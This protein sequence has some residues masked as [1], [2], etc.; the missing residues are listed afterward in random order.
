[1]GQAV[2]ERGRS[3]GGLLREWRERRRLSQLALAH[4]AEISPRHLSFVETGRARPSREMVL[5]LAEHLNVPL[6][7]RNHLLLAAGYAP[8][9]P[10][11]ALDSP[12]LRRVRAA[13]RLVLRAHE[14]WP[15]VAVDRLWRLVDANAA[16]PVLTAGAAPHLLRPPVNALR[17]TLH[18]EG[19]APRVVNLGQWRTH[20]L[21]RLRRQAALTA[22]ADLAALHDELSG[23]P[24]G[25]PGPAPAE[26]APGDV[27]VPLRLRHGGGELHLLS[28]VSTFGTPLDVTVAE[29]SI[30]TFLPADEATAEA[31]RGA[32]G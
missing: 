24:G 23:Y 32:V 20:V 18:P 17:L 14:P 10:Q 8:A 13:V 1:M 5:R 7:D 25:T 2:R 29:L 30:E 6:R 16:V 27:V 12:E 28:T 4:E 22:D 11:A 26:P 19:L 15:A 21:G 3:V 31:L 9:Y